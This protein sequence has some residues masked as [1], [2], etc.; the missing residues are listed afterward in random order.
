MKSVYL[1]IKEVP[2]K[3]MTGKDECYTYYTNEILDIFNNF[4]D[5][6]EFV[7][8]VVNDF[9]NDLNLEDLHKSICIKPESYIVE[10]FDDD[11]NV[12]VKYFVEQKE[13]K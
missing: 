4:N 6:K 3:V 2:V 10:I 7:G 13:I 9:F 8:E 12:I 5:A 11:M 1:V